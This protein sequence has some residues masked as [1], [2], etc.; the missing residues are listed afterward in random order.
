LDQLQPIVSFGAARNSMLSQT[1]TFA[2]ATGNPKLAFTESIGV[3]ASPK[4]DPA[5]ATRLTKAFM[6]AG[7]DTDV[8]GMAEA[9]NIPLAVNG[10]EVLAETMKRNEEVLAQVLG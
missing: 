8:L 5:L 6:V 2:E 1:P 9:G 4:L 3:F 7:N 10:P